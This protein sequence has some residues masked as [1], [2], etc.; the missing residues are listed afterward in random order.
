MS[1][2]SDDQVR[3]GYLTHALLAQLYRWWQFY[4][5][6]ESTLANQ[7][8]ILAENV[9]IDSSGNAVDS[10]A[11]YQAYAESLPQMQNAHWPNMSSMSV[12]I[13]DSTLSASLDAKYVNIGALPD[14]A[15]MNAGVHYDVELARSDDTVLPT[16]TKILIAAGA[17]D[18][19]TEFVDAYANNRVASLVHYYLA[20]LGD[21]AK[22]LDP[23]AELFADSFELHFSGTDIATFDEFAEWVEGY[24]ALTDASMLTMESMDV[25]ENS[26]GTLTV[27]ID[28]EWDGIM[29]DGTR[30]E[31]GTRHVWNVVDD[32]SQRFARICSI[33]VTRTR[34]M[35]SQASS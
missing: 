35:A 34:D 30:M 16:F 19:S 1:A 23:F 18:G 21:P 5:R 14:G 17:G 15:V 28:F 13:G 8:D 26:D 7:L 3:H 29:P 11:A 10:R 32:P 31:M 12:D 2:L 22:R 24:S 6:P 25:A 4:E 20:L 33:D 27:T 9:H